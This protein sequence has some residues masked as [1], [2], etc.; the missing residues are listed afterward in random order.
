MCVD[1]CGET[2]QKGSKGGE[3]NGPKPADVG[4]R[5]EGTKERRKVRDAGPDVDNI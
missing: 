1:G 5:N 3:S 2:Y 4:V